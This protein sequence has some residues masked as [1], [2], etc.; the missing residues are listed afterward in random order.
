M[1]YAIRKSDI[2]AAAKLMYKI[3]I[4]LIEEKINSREPPKVCISHTKH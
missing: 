2:A 4:G 3:A 1:L